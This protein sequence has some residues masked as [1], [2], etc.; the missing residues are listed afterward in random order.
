MQLRIGGLG[1]FRPRED[2]KREYIDSPFDWDHLNADTDMG[3]DMLCGHGYLTYGIR[4]NY[5]EDYDDNH[6]SHNSR[7]P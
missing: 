5:N 2:E 4:L 7:K 6:S 1:R 3:P